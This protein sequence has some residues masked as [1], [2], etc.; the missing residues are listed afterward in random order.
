MYFKNWLLEADGTTIWYH[1]SPNL[2]DSFRLGKYKR[3]MQL[4]FGIHFAQNK[5]FA[6]LYGR[7]IYYCHL[8]PQNMFDAT[9]IYSIQRDPQV[10]QMAKEMVKGS[11][12]T[13]PVSEGDKFVVYLDGT[14]PKRA[15]A[16]LKKYGYD[17]ALYSAKHGSQALGGMYVNAKSISMTMLDPN[18]IKILKVEDLEA[19]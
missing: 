13:V 19:Q 15:E 10:Y 18:Q 2:F 17:A 16:L 3:N 6:Q 11:R 4:G 14:S 5:E 1:G 8:S 9:A 7:Y 12:F